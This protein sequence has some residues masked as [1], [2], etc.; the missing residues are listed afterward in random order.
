MGNKDPKLEKN[1]CHKNSAFFDMVN[2]KTSSVSMWTIGEKIS[3]S[4]TSDKYSISDIQLEIENVYQTAENNSVSKHPA[5]TII[6]TEDNRKE[7]YPDI[8]ETTFWKSDKDPDGEVDLKEPVYAEISKTH[9]N[10]TL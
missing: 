4:D 9:K 6:P 8:L 5:N 7:S 1:E 10:E 3:N 2:S